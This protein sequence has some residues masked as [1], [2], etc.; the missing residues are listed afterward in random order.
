[1]T[2]QRTI[3]V[4][5]AAG[6]LGTLL[7]ERLVAARDVREVVAVDVRAPRVHGA[8]LRAVR[9]DV[10]DPDLATRF[11]GCD[12]VV[13]LAFVVTQHLPRPLVDSINVEG[14]RNVARAA[15]AAGVPHLV[16]LSSIAAYGVVPG[17]P[18]PIVEE[19]RRRHQPDFAYAATKFE[20]E[21][22]LDAFE[23]AHPEM[24]VTR[25]RPS[26][27][28]GRGM[29]HPF[30]RMLKA[31]TL[32]D[33]GGQVLPVVWDEDVVDAV[34]LALTARPRGAFN[35]SADEPVDAATVGRA[36]GMRVLQVS[37]R[38]AG[39]LVRAGNA[40][41]RVGLGQ[42][43]DPSWLGSGGARMIVS[44]AR[45]RGELGWRPRCGT[46]LDVM[47]H[48]VATVPRR[49]D[50][51]LA[52]LL[53]LI[54]LAGRFGPK[55]PQLAGITARVHLRVTGAGGGDVTLD[56]RGGRLRVVFGAPADPSA[57]VTLADRLL[58]D[59]F[60]GRA[61]FTSALLGGRLR[62]D[63]LPIAGIL[64]AA[65]VTNFRAAASAPGASGAL[66]RLIVRWC[67]GGA[68]A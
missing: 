47:R 44:S 51:R 52:A 20:V 12:A 23:P 42:S 61:N 32:L 59:L 65:M 13:H 9:A 30:G 68:T 43:M 18:E 8:K 17:H 10:R 29:D 39:L 28:V 38:V 63:G 3:A 21:A 4:T 35:L 24:V 58:L 64:V 14:S 33:V 1:M 6:Y 11:T 26:I 7:L 19:T 53:R 27:Y 25:L 37:P 46:T 66:P 48:F 2:K 34:V 5:G 36:T 31:R 62:V 45:A 56:V 60:G 55:D 67:Q 40:A 15:A 57:V 50:R 41:A 22:F 49:L 16:F 54:G